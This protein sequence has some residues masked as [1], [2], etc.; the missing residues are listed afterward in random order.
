MRKWSLINVLIIL[1]F[2]VIDVYGQNANYNAKKI[3][4]IDLPKEPVKIICLHRDDN[5]DWLKNFSIDVENI[6][7]RPIVELEC[8]LIFNKHIKNT[9]II[10]IPLKF[11]KDDLA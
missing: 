8:D 7:G 3:T 10:I 2:S 1:I 9:G 5:S 4:K 11:D 6:S